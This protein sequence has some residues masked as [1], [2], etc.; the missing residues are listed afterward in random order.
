MKCQAR[1]WAAIKQKN[2]KTA[3][4]ADTRGWAISSRPCLSARIRV[5]RGFIPNLRRGLSLFEVIIALAIFM[6]AI[7]AIGELVSNGVRGAVQARLQTQAVL[8]A[9]TRLGEVVAG[10]A[11]L[12]G[13]TSGTFTDDP[14]WSWSVVVTTGPHPGL[15]IVDVTATHA[16]ATH[17][18]N[19][20]YSLRRLVR[21]P[22]VAL[23]AYAKQQEDAANAS[24]TSGG[25]STGS[26]TGGSK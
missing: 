21:D 15:Y 16:S 8:R 1:P 10:I 4:Y 19:Q 14:S 7:C 12:H 9:E 11:P 25:S 5:I 23:D 18:G 26:S 22:Q 17:A 2:K 13:A 20:S 3:D 24:S 6:G